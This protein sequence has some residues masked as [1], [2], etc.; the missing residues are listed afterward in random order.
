MNYLWDDFQIDSKKI[1][2]QNH[3]DQDWITKRAKEDINFWPDEWIR[4]YKWEMIGFKDTKLVNKEGKSFFR[5]PAK[6]QPGN[7]VAVFHGAPNPMEC[8]DKFVEDNWR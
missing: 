1:M 4:S 6:V 3:G 2:S 7:K 5:T 8:A